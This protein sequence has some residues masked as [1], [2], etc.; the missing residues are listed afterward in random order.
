MSDYNRNFDP[1]GLAI[2]NLQGAQQA[3]LGA[4][5]RQEQR[6]TQD[7]TAARANLEELL[8]QADEALAVLDPNDPEDADVIAQLQQERT[9]LAERIN[10]LPAD[11]AYQASLDPGDSFTRARQ[12]ATQARQER[13][14]EVA[15]QQH[16]F[17]MEIENYRGELQQALQSEQ[18]GFQ[19]DQ[20]A[21]ERAFERA[22][23]EADRMWQSGEAELDRALEITMQN[24]GFTFQGGQAA[25]DRLLSRWTTRRQA[26]TQNSI[27]NLQ[28]DAE[29]NTWTRDQLAQQAQALST[30]DPEERAQAE[31]EFIRTLDANVRERTITPGQR[32]ALL[33]VSRLS[34]TPANIRARAEARQAEAL[35]EGEEIATDAARLDLFMDRSNSV[36]SIAE[37]A[38]VA[39][40]DGLTGLVETELARAQAI[41]NGAMPG[42]TS[43]QVDAARALLERGDE[44]IADSEEARQNW[45][46]TTHETLAQLREA[47]RQAEI[48]TEQD[49]IGTEQAEIATEQAEANLDQT[50]MV[51]REQLAAAFQ[52]P[53]TAI[54]SLR[55]VLSEEDWE[56]LG[57][58]RYAE[59]TIRYSVES[60]QRA[61]NQ[62]QDAQIAE[63]IRT[64]PDLDDEAGWRQAF[65]DAHRK[66]SVFGADVSEEALD[67]L[68]DLYW[69]AGQHAE[70]SRLMELAKAEAD[71]MMA[72]AQAGYYDRMPTAGGGGG[73]G[74]D[75]YEVIG[76]SLDHMQFI[77]EEARL[78]MD[79]KCGDVGTVGVN[80]DACQIAT[81]E[82][83]LARN[84]YT[85]ALNSSRVGLGLQSAPPTRDDV[86]TALGEAKAEGM[87]RDGAVRAFGN[88]LRFYP[89]L[90]EEHFPAEDGGGQAG[91]QE[92]TSEQPEPEAPLGTTRGDRTR[93]GLE[94][95]GRGLAEGTRPVRE[96]VG[97]AVRAA[98]QAIGDALPERS[99]NGLTFDEKANLLP[100][101]RAAGVDTQDHDALVEW[102]EGHKEQQALEERGGR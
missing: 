56:R 42:S 20:G 37:R 53:D 5:E 97:G 80:S 1:F 87:T 46:D 68:A 9:G 43:E 74:T 33:G 31:E 23:A 96:A 24:A 13:E 76:G 49:E 88:S 90:L 84:A 41:V 64:N 26:E 47:T 91:G 66:D 19:G 17:T 30:V 65:K 101:A 29:T 99:W 92:A 27:A 10:T 50:R 36:A 71:V 83:N 12:A 44:L 75:P 78:N 82:Y 34:D 35:A 2:Q 100:L 102:Y 54:T 8:S 67:R 4:I 18:L 95:A 89:D 60:R 62:T 22:M 25:K 98:G 11:Q 77:V 32:T 93:I 15:E 39:A 21:A 48:A 85:E 73:S 69:Q 7:R 81:N 63:A 6:M 72:V 70:D 16:E 55:R 38:N 45:R 14:D 61:R 79:A 86:D 52:D 3:G 59:A 28:V 51:A 57:G 40:R 94:L 58:Q